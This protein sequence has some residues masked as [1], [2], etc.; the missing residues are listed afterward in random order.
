MLFNLDPS[1]PAQEVLF[2]RKKKIHF[3]PTITLSK[4]QVERVSYGKHLG[5]LLDN[6]LNFKQHID[7][8][9]SKVNKGISVKEKTS[10]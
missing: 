7:S 6:I 8:A 5:I 3:H 2:S 4:V 1:E 10:T 9:I